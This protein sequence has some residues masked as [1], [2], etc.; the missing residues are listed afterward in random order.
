MRL[1]QTYHI[2]SRGWD[3]IGYN[4]LVGGDGAV[5]VGRGWNKQG[6]HTKGYN[7]KSICVAFI[8]TFNKVLPPKR[9]LDAAQKILE[10][11][12]KLK[13]L[14]KDYRLYGHRQLMGTESPGE[15]LYKVIK[16]WPHWSEQI[17]PP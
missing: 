7:V 13:K 1:I 10:E 14:S 8:G 16:T 11:G 17:V 12:V 6:A 3:D 4:F 2:E 5:Y 15:A 9:Q